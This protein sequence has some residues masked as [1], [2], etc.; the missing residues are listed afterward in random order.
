MSKKKQPKAK[1]FTPPEKWDW[2]TMPYFDDVLLPFRPTEVE[3]WWAYLGAHGPP[4]GEREWDDITGHIKN[5]GSGRHKTITK[6]N[7]S[8]GSTGADPTML[9]EQI[10]IDRILAYARVRHQHPI[11]VPAVMDFSHFV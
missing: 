11:T 8:R 7:K 2:Y 4:V 1:V 10:R 3:W 5:Y 6:I 9:I